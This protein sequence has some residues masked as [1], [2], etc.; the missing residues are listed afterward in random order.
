M[1]ISMYIYTCT[2]KQGY[3]YIW[4]SLYQTCR[5]N[6]YPI[7]RVVFIYIYIYLYIHLFRVLP[8]IGRP[9]GEHKTKY[10][11]PRP[12]TELYLLGTN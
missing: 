2:P 12:N 5:S 1:Y 11:D 10:K 6:G 4:C 7:H 3:P 9:R 8:Y